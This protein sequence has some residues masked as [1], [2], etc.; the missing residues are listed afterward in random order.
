MKLDHN[1]YLVEKNK[2]HGGIQYKYL[3]PNGLGASLV[4]H[5]GSYGYDKG[6]WEIA[7][8]GRDYD[9]IGMSVLQWNDDVKG[10]L[11]AKESKSILNQIYNIES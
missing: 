9:F 2:M 7:A 4:R 10:Y 3:F 8:L 1:I 11:T 6:L 5:E